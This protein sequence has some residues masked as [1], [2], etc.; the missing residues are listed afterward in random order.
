MCETFDNNR[1]LISK[2]V[3]TKRRF[4]AEDIITAYKSE[5][6]NAIID[7]FETIRGFLRGLE[8]HGALKV[9]HGQYVVKD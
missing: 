9:E 4:T 6:G 5:R 1:R 2:L 7:G 3:Y 8:E